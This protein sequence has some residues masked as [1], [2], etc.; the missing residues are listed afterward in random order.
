LRDETLTIAPPRPPCLADIRRTASRA[1][2]RAGHVGGEH[3][4]EA[5]RIHPLDARLRPEHPRIV[6]QRGERTETTIDGSEQPHDVGLDRESACTAIARRPARAT[7][8]TAAAAA[9]S[10]RR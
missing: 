6:D 2:E 1:H 9:R 8:A 5:C 3:A 4:R 7:S 10:L